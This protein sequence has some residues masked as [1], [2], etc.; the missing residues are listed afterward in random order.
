MRTLWP[1]PERDAVHVI[2]QRVLPHRLRVERLDSVAAVHTAIRD[3][4]VRGAPLIGATA[5]YGLALQARHDALDASLRETADFLGSA[6]PT[7]VNLAWALRRM[8]D[9]LLGLPLPERAA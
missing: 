1:T 8:L 7:A 6:R 4:W 5:A 9:A 3:M 2:D